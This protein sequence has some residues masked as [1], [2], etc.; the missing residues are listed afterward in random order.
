MQIEMT[1]LSSKGKRIVAEQSGHYI[2]LQ[3]PEIVIEAIKE[4]I[5]ELRK[6]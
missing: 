3:Q 4:V 5:S 2:H 1:G 6:I